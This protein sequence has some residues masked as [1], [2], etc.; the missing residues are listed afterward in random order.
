MEWRDQ[1][2]LLSVRKH[3]EGSAIVDIL[4]QEHGRHSG[5]IRGGAGRRM[6]PVLQLGARLDVAWRARLEAHLGAFTVEPIKSRAAV[7]LNDRLA[8]AGLNAVCAM[9]HVT[10][11]ERIA[12]PQLYAHTERLLDLLPQTDLFPLAYVQ[13]EM[14]VLQEIG[15]G[16]D[17]ESCAVTGEIEDLIYISPKSGRAVSR[18]GAGE[19]A[20]RLLPLPDCLKHTGTGQDAD[21]LAGLQVLEFFWKSKVAKQLDLTDMPSAR[22]RFVDIFARQ[23][24]S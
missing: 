18:Q 2:V 13:W 23:V 24:S 8:L 10:L 1:G 4:T 15:F 22:A 5:I 21:V 9:A 11:A 14:Q 3:G 16:L 6:A 17:L 12:C 19:W 7:A 20:D